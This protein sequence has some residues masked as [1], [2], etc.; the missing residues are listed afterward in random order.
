[1]NRPNV[2]AGEIGKPFTLSSQLVFGVNSQ[3]LQI[4]WFRGSCYKGSPCSLHN[5]LNNDDYQLDGTDL[6]IV[7]VNQSDGPQWCTQRIPKPSSDKTLSR[8]LFD[9]DEVKYGKAFFIPFGEL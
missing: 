5:I 6:R 3:L 7:N 9:F 2:F 1:M 4:E 8:L